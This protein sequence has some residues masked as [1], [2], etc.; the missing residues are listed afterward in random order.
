MLKTRNDIALNYIAT[1]DRAP[2]AAGLD[3]WLNDSPLKT[4][5]EIAQSFFD[6]PETKEKYP[7]GMGPVEFVKTIY[8]NLFNRD[9]DEKGWDY[10]VQELNDGNI[11]R[12]N[13][14]L[15]VTNGALDTDEYKDKTI[16]DNKLEVGLYFADKGLDDVEEATTVMATVT[17]DYASVAHAKDMINDWKYEEIEQ[18]MTIDEDTIVGTSDTDFVS[19]VAFN[20]D[21]KD[22]YQTQDSYDGKDGIDIINVI[23]KSESDFTTQT[24]TIKNV[25]KLFV[26]QNGS[27]YANIDTYKFDDALDKILFK[28]SADATGGVEVGAVHNKLSAVGL[29]VSSSDVASNLKVVFD[30]GAVAGD[31]DE[32]TVVVKNGLDYTLNLQ[33]NSSDPRGAY[34]TYTIDTTYGDEKHLNIMDTSLENINIIGN[35]NLSLSVDSENIKDIDATRL[36]GNLNIDNL[37]VIKGAEISLGSG[38]DYIKVV[39]DSVTIEANSGNDTLIGGDGNDVLKGGSGNDT[40]KGGNGH[41]DIYGGLGADTITVNGADVNKIIYTNYKDSLIDSQDIIKGF[42]TGSDMLILSDVVDSLGGTSTGKS[43]SSG[44]FI[45]TD[46]ALSDGD[47]FIKDAQSGMTYGYYNT[48]TKELYIDVNQNNTFDSNIDTVIFIEDSIVADDIIV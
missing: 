1:F 20:D 21:T 46:K 24:P 11:S 48:T 30:T 13:M 36:N 19:G 18:K 42:V 5:E 22:T 3:Y 35:S 12:G 45:S 6:Q 29:N 2:D 14:I 23:A 26:T 27:G 4:M 16:L 34:E 44:N 43:L 17:D 31:E 38:D 25:E 37:K 41:N 39:S 47:N 9:P 32:I 8:N 10:W 15:A 7:D 28:S 33:D 40:I